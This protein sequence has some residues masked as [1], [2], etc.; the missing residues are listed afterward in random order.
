[1]AWIIMSRAATWP[2]PEGAFP[3]RALD[4]AQQLCAAIERR[5][6]ALGR[7]PTSTA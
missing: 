7:L 2:G 6:D 5:V 3:P 4:L 1:M